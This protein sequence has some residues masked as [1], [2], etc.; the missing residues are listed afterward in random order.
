MNHNAAITEVSWSSH[1]D[2]LMALRMRVFVQEQGIALDDEVDPNDAQHR[3]FLA[4]ADSAEAIGCGRMTAQGQIGRMAVLPAHRHKGIGAELLSHI[5]RVAAASGAHCVFLHAQVDA[6]SFY[7]KQGFTGTGKTF[8][9][10]GITH[11]TM[12]RALG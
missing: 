3:H 10:A 4:F 8:M 9:E 11:V 12:R 1:S 2:I 5:V 7:A 6:E